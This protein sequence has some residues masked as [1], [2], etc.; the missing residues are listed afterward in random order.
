MD[1]DI[2][3]FPS[4]WSGPQL[5]EKMNDTG[6]KVREMREPSHPGFYYGHLL[7]YKENSLWNKIPGYASSRMWLGS[8]IAWA[9]M[10]HRLEKGACK[11]RG[12]KAVLTG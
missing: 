8:I 1:Q 4:P 9:F 5:W 11:R 10:E 6:Q 12:A 2:F 7:K 3:L